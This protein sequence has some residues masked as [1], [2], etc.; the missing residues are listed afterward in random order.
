VKHHQTAASVPVS[1]QESELTLAKAICYALGGFSESERLKVEVE[2]ERDVRLQRETVRRLETAADSF[3][4][5]PDE[6]APAPSPGVKARLFRSIDALSGLE[7]FM[8]RFAAASD[9]CIVITDTDSHI[10]WANAA[11]S[12][13]CG[14]TLGEL[15]GKRPGQLLHG[16]R[17][18]A[19]VLR[20]LRK[21]IRS[22]KIRTEEVI[23]YHKD[24]HPY[25]VRLTI[26]PIVDTE[27]KARG[28]ISI[29][30]ELVSKPV[31]R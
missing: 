7:T 20:R 23:N 9:D 18:G 16:S 29:E 4:F 22:R 24:G 19:R 3:L 8:A 17:T 11:F 27:G 30:K 21:A 5:E 31:P 12:R 28:F 13:M 26:C 1:P 15:Q 14:Y 10:T 6:D 25:W 2:M